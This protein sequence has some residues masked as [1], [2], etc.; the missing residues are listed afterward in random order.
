MSKESKI[1][2]GALIVSTIFLTVF[3]YVLHRHALR[4]SLL[5]AQNVNKDVQLASSSANTAVAKTPATVAATPAET[6]A[7]KTASASATV[8]PRTNVRATSTPQ[9]TVQE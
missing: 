1:V 7:Q 6:P 9:A 8:R 3:Q 2:L 5:A 4:V